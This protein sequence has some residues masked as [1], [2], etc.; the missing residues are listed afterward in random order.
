[1]TWPP[2]CPNCHAHHINSC[3]D[4][5][6]N[7]RLLARIVAFAHATSMRT[8]MHSLPGTFRGPTWTARA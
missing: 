5:K 1:M 7:D 4:A 2:H 3:E 6:E 8:P